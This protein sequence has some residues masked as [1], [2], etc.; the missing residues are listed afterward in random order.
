MKNCKP[1]IG[2]KIYVPSSCYVYRGE[3]DFE[4]GLATISKV[5]INKY[6]SKDNS[7]RIFIEIEERRAT[8]YNWKFLLEEQDELKEEFGDRVA[9]PNPDNRTEF[10]NQNADW[11]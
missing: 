1:I 7:N 6:L 8:S 10:N 3:D 11:R 4:G 5:I 2:E 9:H